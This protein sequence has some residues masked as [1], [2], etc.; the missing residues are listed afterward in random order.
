VGLFWYKNP[1]SSPTSDKVQFL[2]LQSLFAE[3]LKIDPSQVET[4]AQLGEWP[5]WDSMAHM[6]LMLALESRFDVE[7][8]AENISRLISIPAILEYL[9]NRG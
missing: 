4:N 5:L 1:M 9:Q 7:I 2:D 8:N 3:V 6:D